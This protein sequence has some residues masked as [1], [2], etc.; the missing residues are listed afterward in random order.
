M[1][2]FAVLSTIGNLK[3][4]FSLQQLAS[5]FYYEQNKS[6]TPSQHLACIFVNK[7]KISEIPLFTATRK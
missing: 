3:K 4:C 7:N 5:T 2:S 6:N 1:P